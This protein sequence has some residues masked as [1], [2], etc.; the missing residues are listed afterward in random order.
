MAHHRQTATILRFS[1]ANAFGNWQSQEFVL[2]QLRCW[3]SVLVGEQAHR[4]RGR[5]SP[6]STKAPPNGRCTSPTR[7]QTVFELWVLQSFGSVA[8]A[9]AATSVFAGCVTKHQ[10]QAQDAA[11]AGI[12]GS[13]NSEDVPLFA[14]DVWAALAQ[15]ANC[16]WPEYLQAFSSRFAPVSLAQVSCRRKGC[17]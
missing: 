13:S 7:P 14:G 12:S 10:W 2:A 8:F 4:Q 9:G 1:Q 3:P 17:R 16:Q 6:A 11:G 5:P 15:Q